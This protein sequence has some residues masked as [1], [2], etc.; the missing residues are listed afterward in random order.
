MNTY[1]CEEIATLQP[2]MYGKCITAKVISLICSASIEMNGTI[3]F[4]DL[5]ISKIFL[6]TSL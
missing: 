2:G 1:K 3:Y 6:F 4:I 5:L